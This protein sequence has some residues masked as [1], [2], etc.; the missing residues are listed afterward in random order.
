MAPQGCVRRPDHS[1]GD[2]YLRGNFVRRTLLASI[3]AIAVLASGVLIAG[4]AT[5]PKPREMKFAC[6]KNSNGALRYVSRASGCKRTEKAITISDSAPIDVCVRARRTRSLPAGSTR[7]VDAVTRC[8]TARSTKETAI[9]VPGPKKLWFCAVK[10]T[11]ALRNVASRSRCSK[12]ADLA[13]FVNEAKPM[14]PGPQVTPQQP[15]PNRA[16]TAN[17]DA[18]AT[19]E[20]AGVAIAPLGNDSDP[21]G[22]V[23]S[24]AS[25]DGTGAAGSVSVSP[26]GTIG[27]DPNGAFEDLSPGETETDSFTYRATDGS[28]QSGPATVRLTIEGANDAPEPQTSSGS[29]AYTEGASPVA[30]DP[31]VAVDDV[32]DVN[33]AGATARITGGYV[34]NEDALSFD[35]PSGSG[36]TGTYDS[37]TGVLTLT[38]T[39]TVAQYE[40]VLRSVKFETAGDGP[41]P[42]PR[43]VEFRVRDASDQ[44]APAS[45]ALT[46][47]GVNDAPFVNTSAGTASYTENGAGTAVDPQI[48]VG[49]PDSVNFKGARVAISS[50]IAEDQLL[51]IPQNGITGTYDSGTG[52]LTLTGQATRAQYRQALTSVR[53]ANLSDHPSAAT[54]TVSFRV[55]DQFDL[56]SN[57]VARTVT[58]E[59]VNDA[60]VNTLPAG[61]TIDEGGSTNFGAGPDF[62]IADPDSDPDI[63]TTT[64]SAPDG[65]IAV[66]SGSGSVVDNG[67]SVQ[68]T[69]TAAQI[70]ERL[71]DVTYTPPADVDQNRSIQV[72]TNDGGHNGSGP[73][74]TDTDAVTVTI[75][76][77][78]DPP[79]ITKPSNQ[80][81]D[82]DAPLTFAAPANGVSVADVD[83][84]SDAISTTVSVGSGTLSIGLTTATNS[85]DDAASIT[86]TGTVA[87][88]NYALEGMV[89]HPAQNA[90]GDD[91]LTVSADDGGNNGAATGSGQTDSE[92]VTITRTAVNDAPVVTTTVGSTTFTEGV[93]P[94]VVDSGLTVSDVENQTISS[95]TAK[96]TAGYANDASPADHDTLA[97]AEDHGITCSYD[98]SSGTLTLTGT[99][100]TDDYQDVLRSVTFHNDSENS[101]TAA[102]TVTFKV[103]E[104]GAGGLTSLGADRGVSV[105]RVNDPPVLTTETATATAY[106]ENDPATVV[107]GSITVSDVDS[108]TLTG[109]TATI[110][111][112]HDDPEDVLSATGGSGV[113][114][115]GYDSSTGVLTLS[116]TASVSAYEA[117]LRS[118]QY[119][120]T[121]D[122]PSAGTR[123]VSFR[124]D[125]GAAANN[126][127]DVAS[128]NVTVAAVNDAPTVLTS[129]GATVFTE[130]ATAPVVIDD[131]VS[132][133]DPDSAELS[134][135]IVKITDGFQQF[136]DV[137]SFTSNHGIE[138]NVNAFYGELHLQ[139]AGGG[140]APIADFQAAAREVEFRVAS[141]APG[142]SREISFLATDSLSADSAD[143][144]TARKQITIQNVNNAPQITGVGSAAVDYTEDQPAVPVAGD[145]VVSDPDGPSDN[146]TGGTVKITTGFDPGDVLEFANQGGV[147]G[148]YSAGV[149]T[150][151][152]GGTQTQYQNFLRSVKFR[153]DDSPG[154]L[155]RNIEF[156]VGDDADE[157]NL[158]GNASAH[159]NVT[160]VPDSPVVTTSSGSTAYTEGAPAVTVDSAVTVADADQPMTLSS[161]TVHIAG[162]FQSTDVLAWTDQPGITVTPVPATGTLSLSGAASPSAYQALMRSVQF[163]SP[164]D[165][166]GPSRTIEFSVDDGTG[167]GGASNVATRQ[168]AIDEVNDAPV[169]GQ[170]DG[171]LTYTEDDPSENH[172][173]AVAPNLTLTDPDDANT[174]SGTVEIT[175]NHSDGDELLFT[176]Q[177]SITGTGSGTNSLTLTGS[178]TKADWQ[179]ALRSVR[180]RN[181]SDDPSEAT[182][183]VTFQVSD[184]D[185]V[186]NA[187]SN[188]ATR[189]IDV[190]ATNDAPSGDAETFNGVKRA[191]GNTDLVVDDP[192]DG[193]PT[194]TTPKK[195]VTGDILD[196][197]SDAEGDSFHAVEET[198]TTDLGGTADIEEDGDVVF[199]PAAGCSEHEDS[200]DYHVM[201]GED[202]GTGTV[203]IEIQDCVW[204]ADAGAAPGGDGTSDGPFTTLDS[205]NGFVA[206]VD[207]PGHTLYLGAGAYSGGLP[208]EDDQRLHTV[209]HGLTMPDGGTGT[210][211]LEAADSAASITLNGGLVLADDNDVQGIDLGSAA[212]NFALRGTSVGTAHVND[213]TAGS[214]NNPSGGAIGI[215]VSNPLDTND[216]DIAMANVTSSGAGAEAINLVNVDGTVDLGGGT[217]SN[218]ATNTVAING[219]DVDFTYA[220]SIDDDEGRLVDI[221]NKEG[222]TNDFNG[223]VTNLPLT[224]PVEGADPGGGISLQS[225]D[226]VAPDAPEGTVNDSLTRF[227]GGVTIG[228][229]TANGVTATS[230]GRLA[231][232][233]DHNT[234]TTNE[235]GS[236]LALA[237]TPFDADGVTFESLTTKSANPGISLQATGPDG[238]LTVT[239]NA[240]GDPG[241]GGTLLNSVGRG[242]F[243]DT[244]P[245]GVDLRHMN[246]TGGGDDGVR[247]LDVDGLT[248]S[249][250]TVSNNGNAT[251]E[252]GFEVTGGT[253]TLTDLTVSGNRDDGVRIDADLTRVATATI[254]DS[255]IS[256]PATPGVG[257]A[258]DLQQTSGSA[259]V[260]A[261]IDGNTL[262][263]PAGSGLRA[264]SRATGA[265]RALVTDNDV[266]AVAPSTT[267]YSQIGMNFNQHGSSRLDATV[268]GNTIATPGASAQ[269]GLRA[270]AGDPLS[271]DSGTLCLDAGDGTNAAL[272][273]SLTGSGGTGGV[274]IVASQQG[275]TSFLLPGYTG[276]ANDTAAVQSYL[277]ARND[278]NGTP[279]ALAVFSNPPGFADGTCLLP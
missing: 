206:N 165:D 193:A 277:Q 18:V 37:G 164:S 171:L 30:A 187:E 151:T 257:D 92:T 62:L 54:R 94:Q 124:V 22:N 10:K 166:P 106:T 157:N 199:H 27:Y 195:T 136:D 255:T 127:S 71:A 200:F 52:V 194:V 248:M 152:G 121:S 154:S 131:G 80:T 186:E 115:A 29:A 56:D 259:Q 270:L 140:T 263:A 260:H 217:L 100:S 102:R 271:G 159:V 87:Q 26:D 89:Y 43:A 274:D 57:T 237:F 229:G 119:R 169:L 46:V 232:S 97:C 39:A 168:I 230:G 261:T 78:N 75:N 41:S 216:V 108:A 126:L 254:S 180:Y 11:G 163:S 103:T 134:R 64:L 228:T 59:P 267:A 273:N 63:L 60:P 249:D 95:A 191:V 245:D 111:A 161:G 113:V 188:E 179:A 101:S 181:T 132:I 114:V 105:V 70:N 58:V 50:A 265:L 244:V 84:G 90:T 14:Q 215:G 264:E 138:G 141:A 77:Q 66:G 4:A 196:G 110:S 247:A 225:N 17:D 251:G 184:G 234:I 185:L 172:E 218:A 262:S 65:D 129:A 91:T 67:E 31:G 137:L 162:G 213:A 167:M 223:L 123:T 235:G 81:I 204:Y 61:P 146:M 182:R 268:R 160:A 69:G 32:D 209:R 143:V 48:D 176:N 86:L 211:T 201:D 33:L 82:E 122:D 256:A 2:S 183:T 7:L 112:G 153:T 5:A 130:N 28:L 275:S 226:V 266:Q 19:G 6:A 9:K 149:L 20:D 276:A 208:L 258:I 34:A 207:G 117:A 99:R 177:G 170:P 219:G 53:Y 189:D 128:H 278:G 45:R 76:A 174:Q 42:N 116:G 21:D 233:G 198:V 98:A 142:D 8:S 13:V 68:I 250:S 175:A 145:A 222:G 47:T 252:R 227:D 88:I 279:S 246:V 173:V 197:D 221:R 51:F 205:L 1:Q 74:G 272:K 144:A 36:I 178:A 241:S 150:I 109:A 12:K 44:S 212:S 118:V 25:V 147:T 23:L 231:I 135:V 202:T 192:S 79:V 125:D 120:N 139:K 236:A 49:D 40:A 83:A 72:V 107:D 35:P 104:T 16:P 24:V 148:A 158:S 15:T 73:G 156:Q 269:A 243:L 210:V 253:A 240:A 155:G 220:G 38:G 93:G 239:G 214:I 238:H 203:T 242:V 224:D 55:R 85:A 190:V 96:I 133:T 3:A